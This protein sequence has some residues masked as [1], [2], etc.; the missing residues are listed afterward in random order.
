MVTSISLGPTEPSPVETQPLRSTADGLLFG[1]YPGSGTGGIDP[2][3][4]AGP[5]DDPA[6]INVAL[7][8][9]Q[10]PGR[11]LM[12]RGYAHYVGS[13]RIA[14]ATPADMLQYIRDGRQ[15]DLVLCYRSPDGD[16][17]DW[18][19]FVRSIIRKY[20]PALAKLQLT[21]EPNNPDPANGGDGSSPNVVQ[22][23]IEGVLAARD[24]IQRQG[25]AIQIGFNATISFNPNDAFWNS[26]ARLG[27]PAFMEAL[28]YVGLDFFP[29]VFRPLPR[30]PDG[31]PMTLQDAVSMVLTQFRNVC[32]AAG[33]IPAS[34]PIHITEHGWPTSPTRSY[35]QQAETLETV[36]R[37][38]YALRTEHRITHYEFFDLR[39]TDSA[40]P[41]FQFGLLRDDYTPKPAFERYRQL[42]VELSAQ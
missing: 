37:T 28:D 36:V 35:A 16:L 38:I 11:P 10:P 39:D 31:M 5:P 25:Y 9:L 2:L 14:S 3:L 19:N 24:E 1:I 7:A 27:H 13:G 18:T 4:F 21:E 41:G 34:V 40:D 12:I 26:I 20:G 23:I 42:I 15:L 8:Q 33:N 30:R 22:A 6:Q 17:A 29:D 32:L